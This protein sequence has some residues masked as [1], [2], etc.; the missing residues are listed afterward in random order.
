M[1]YTKAMKSIQ[2]Q[3]NKKIEKSSRPYA[4]VAEAGRKVGEKMPISVGHFF[5]VKVYN[6]DI[7][8]AEQFD[9]EISETDEK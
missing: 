4:L 1:G 2:E 8:E 3:M 6:K 9:T 5:L 7:A